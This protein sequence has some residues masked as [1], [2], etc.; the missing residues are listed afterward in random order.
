[1]PDNSTTTQQILQDIHEDLQLIIEQDKTRREGET[2]IKSEVKDL[3]TLLIGLDGTNG[4]RSESK[5]HD[6]AIDDLKKWKTQVMVVLALM[7]MFFVPIVI[8]LLQQIFK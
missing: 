1:M 5:L 3:R 2:Q 7:Q 4:L 6:A 8:Y